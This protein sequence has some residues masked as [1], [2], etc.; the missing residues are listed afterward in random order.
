MAVAGAQ[1][2][3]GRSARQA[4]RIERDLARESTAAALV[5]L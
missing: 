5:S 4:G 1:V 3:L 2:C